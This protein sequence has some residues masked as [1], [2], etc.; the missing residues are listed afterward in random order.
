MT[1]HQLAFPG[2]GEIRALLRE[3]DWSGFP[4]GPPQAWPSPLRAVLQLMLASPEPSCLAWGPE[5]HCFY[6]DAYIELLGHKHPS[7]LARALWDVWPELRPDVG[8]AVSRALRG[9]PSLQKNM[10]FQIKREGFLESKWFTFSLLPIGD[11]EGHVVGVFSLAMET[12]QQV[13]TE[14]CHRFLLELA[15]RLRPLDA[16][17]L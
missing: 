6:N 1:A 14:Q 9:E 12:T 16:P 8:P 15:D 17:E 13:E 10:P 5:L 7:A 11:E 4:L 2:A 3:R